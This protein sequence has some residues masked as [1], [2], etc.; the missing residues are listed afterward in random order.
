MQSNVLLFSVEKMQTQWSMV[1]KYCGFIKK[2]FFI[3]HFWE[4]I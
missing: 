4:Y 1:L 3:V 2:D